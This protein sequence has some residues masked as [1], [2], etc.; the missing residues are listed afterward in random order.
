MNKEFLKMII[1]LLVLLH[2][3][4]E[5]S[6]VGIFSDKTI[7]KMNEIREYILKELSK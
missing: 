5:N 2:Q 4:E 3:D 7:E 1:D 6:V